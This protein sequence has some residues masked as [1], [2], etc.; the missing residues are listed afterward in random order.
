M[1]NT[2]VDQPSPPQSVHDSDEESLADPQH[3]STEWRQSWDMEDFSSHRSAFARKSLRE[4]AFQSSPYPISRNAIKAILKNEHVEADEKNPDGRTDLSLAIENGQYNLV[5][6]LLENGANPNAREDR[7]RTPF[8]WATT[9]SICGTTQDIYAPGHYNDTIELLLQFGADPNLTDDEGNTPL[10]LAAAIGNEEFVKLV[11]ESG[12]AKINAQGDEEKTPLMCAATGG[13]PNFVLGGNDYLQTRSSR[14]E[15]EPHPFQFSKSGF[16][17]YTGLPNLIFK[18]ERHF[19]WNKVLPEGRTFLSWAVELEDEEIV[20]QLLD[21]GADPNIRDKMEHQMT[22]LIKALK[23]GNMD[24][25]ELLKE[26]DKSSMHILVD[27]ADDIGEEQA[28]DLARKLLGQGYDL[29][30]RDLKGQNP[31]HIACHKGR[32]RLLEEFLHPKYGEQNAFVHGQD[33]S[34]KTPLQYAIDN[35][36]IV[37]LLIEHGADLSDVQA[38]SLFKIREPKP[39]CVQL[40]RNPRANYR[41]LLLIS[42]YDEARELWNPQPGQIKLR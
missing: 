25:V 29:N 20:R 1:D 16:K 2:E 18:L 15:K 19:L 12:R 33:N 40:T 24:M 32:T 23:L 38:A 26:K 11:V 27:E 10:A 39:L 6:L 30:K 28:L 42:D 31:V 17:D 36:D 34:G 35:E 7:N 14:T 13:W 4:A 21:S 8:F 5:E 37:K 3:A 9:R 22:P 41:T